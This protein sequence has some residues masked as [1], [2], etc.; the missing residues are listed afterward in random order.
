MSGFKFI[1][2]MYVLFEM[3]KMGGIC[4]L[5]KGGFAR[6]VRI[7]GAFFIVGN[8]R[9]YVVNYKNVNLIVDEM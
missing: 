4:V 8:I 6:I 2:V 9:E 1:F 3:Y 7:C 5:Y